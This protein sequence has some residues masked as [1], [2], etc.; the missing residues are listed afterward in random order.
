MLCCRF[1]GV[2]CVH[3]LCCTRACARHVCARVLERM[4]RSLACAMCYVRCILTFSLCPLFVGDGG[5]SLRVAAVVVGSWLLLVDVCGRWQA[6][7]LDGVAQL[8]AGTHNTRQSF[9]GGARS[10]AELL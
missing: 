1:V 10:P 2:V 5:V 9:G 7:A 4:L 3:A 6:D 8:V